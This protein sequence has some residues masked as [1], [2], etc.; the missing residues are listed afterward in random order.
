MGLSAGERRGGIFYAIKNILEHS[1]ELDEQHPVRKLTEELWPAFLGDTANPAHWVLGSSAGNV[2]N[3]KCRTAW[4]TAIATTLEERLRKDTFPKR[5]REEFDP[6]EYFLSIPGLL[7][8]EES[9]VFEV[10]AWTEQLAY[11]LRRY[12][13]DFLKRYRRLSD[14]IA[15]IQ[16][17]CFVRF[18]VGTRYAKA[19]LANRIFE[20]LYGNLYAPERDVVT[21]ILLEQHMHHNFRSAL[22]NDE[23]TLER[24]AE[25]HTELTRTKELRSSKGQRRRILIALE[26]AGSHFHYAHEQKILLESLKNEKWKNLEEIKKSLKKFCQKKEPSGRPDN[27]D[28]HDAL[29]YVPYDEREYEEREYEES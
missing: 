13:D 4:D 2:V 1:N 22:H 6:F 21:Q 25:M 28:L 12:R 27:E 8:L 15:K 29:F 19:Y 17:T 23:V 5:K 18:S 10:F 9:A 11:Y 24:L 20:K 16:G 14:L 26:I 3:G 7:E